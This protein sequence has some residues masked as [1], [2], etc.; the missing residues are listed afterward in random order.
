M[1]S[2]TA[3]KWL[4]QN[5]ALVSKANY[6][7][8]QVHEFYARGPTC[9]ELMKVEYPKFLYHKSLEAKVVSSKDEHERLG[10]DW[11]EAPCAE[12]ETY[13]EHMEEWDAKKEDAPKKA[14]KGKKAAS[15]PVEE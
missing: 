3:G 4:V 12:A 13:Q 11:H 6:S 5:S 1:I 15:K 9:G 8:N 10:D 14:S 2:F 7:L